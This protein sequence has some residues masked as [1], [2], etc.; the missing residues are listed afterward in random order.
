MRQTSS[1]LIIGGGIGGL[2][3]AIA[4]SQRGIRCDVVEIKD[5]PNVFGVGINQPGNSMRALRALG[6]AEEVM[7]VGFQFDRWDFCDGDGRVLARCPSNLASDGIPH[8]NALS[9][10]ELHRILIKACN[11]AGV[12]IRYGTT[13]ERLTDSGDEV[14][15]AFTDGR[16]AVYDIVV[17]CD[18]VNS[19]TRKQ[20][21]PDHCD[22][23]FTGAGVWRV[24]VPRPPEADSGALFQAVGAKAGYIPLSQETM[25]LLLV[26]PE[27]PR[28][29]FAKEDLPRMLRERL[30]PFG[31]IVGEVREAITDEH[32]V[33]YGPLHE[34]RI[35][36]S[37]SVGR[38]VVTGDAAHAATPHLTQGAAMALED[39]VVLA[40]EVSRPDR[41]VSDALV[42]F[43][44]RRRER[45]TF[46][47][48]ASKAILNAES[49]I[50][51]EA[52]L[53]QAY[54]RY[55]IDLP[56]AMA[57]IDAVLRQEP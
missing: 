12:D 5:E 39:A 43:A 49:Q 23:E 22:P 54:D 20:T 28:A 35:P 36:S 25:Y 31:G 26:L 48:D 19:K 47:Q 44:D 3:T 50:V 6:V 30:A 57:S 29:R 10:P 45:V 56:P 53:A 13:F 14:G 55:P 4:L 46:V 37:W 24:T 11:A 17:G 32:E 8:N 7:D 2:G 52:S 18:G 9:R 38:V 27:A 21:L 51:D 16:E 42:A 33:V 40:E 34:V 41:P 15:V 1:A